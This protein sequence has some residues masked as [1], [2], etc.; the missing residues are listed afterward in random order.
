MTR[1]MRPVQ[2][3]LSELLQTAMYKEIASEAFYSAGQKQTDDTGARELM[4]ELAEEERRHFRI[5]QEFS[6]T[7]W[8][9]EQLDR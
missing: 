3:E 4:K 8:M 5:L 7:R 1:P 9:N 2:D 6:D